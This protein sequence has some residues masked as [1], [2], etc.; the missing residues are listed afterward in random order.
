MSYHNRNKTLTDRD[1]SLESY[2][3]TLIKN[4]QLRVSKI[5][6]E[7]RLYARRSRCFK[8]VEICFGEFLEL[9]VIIVDFTHESSG[10]VILST[11]S[12]DHIFKVV[13]LG[14]TS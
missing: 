3:M 6:I 10:N 7:I 11:M 14:I 9:N 4:F 13:K 12:S 8:V 1:E 5:S 2:S